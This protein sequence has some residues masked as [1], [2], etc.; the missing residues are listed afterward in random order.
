MIETIGQILGFGALGCCLASFQFST[1]KKFFFL[2]TGVCFLFS[3]HFLMLGGY[4]GFVL[5]AIGTVNFVLYY[6]KN[7]GKPFA[8]RRY[9]LYIFC[10]AY[11]I[12]GAVIAINSGNIID[13]LPSLA[14]IFNAFARFSGDLAVIRFSQLL[15]S[16]PFWF[17]YDFITNSYSG[18]INEGLAFISAL[19]AVIR[20]RDEL[21][22]LKIRANAKIN[23]VLSVNRKREDGYH[24][25]S[26]V[27]QTVDLYDSVYIRRSQTVS[28]RAN[29]APSGEDN[30]CYKAAELFSQYGGANIRIK[31]RIPLAA[32]LGGGSSDAAA[33]LLG[34]NRLYGNP[35]SNEQL[36]ELAMALG[37]DVP[38]F[39]Q[40]GT[41]KIEG[42][43]DIIAPQAP[44]CC[45][46]VIVKDGIKQ[47]TGEMYKKLDEVGLCD[48]STE[49]ESFAKNIKQGNL[50]DIAASIFND[51]EK[52]CDREEI[53]NDLI[54][55]GAV[56]AALSGSG[57]SV[58][59]LFDD[60]DRAKKCAAV[61]STKYK[62]VFAC[63]T[64]EAGIIFE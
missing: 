30:I 14:M 49:V 17:F 1:G 39:L 61:L 48:R 41:A 22:T 53:K 44:L 40:G 21:K 3:L 2:Q 47:S 7:A 35:Y 18:C 4:S 12:A 42:K 55:L 46:V 38:F 62:N 52:T 6:L 28:V 13:F 33:V 27:M 36:V 56:G 60:S 25:L 50:K 45:D 26:T 34:L 37:S 16:S 9:W 24:D 23:L 20:Y 32:G 43:G 58:F 29:G 64:T 59:G 10:M 31:K 8:Q 51:F 19:I 63:H 57:P 5:N 54:S 15:V 11:A